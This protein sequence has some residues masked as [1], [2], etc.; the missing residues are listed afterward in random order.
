MKPTAALT[1]RLEQ[2]RAACLDALRG[3][4]LAAALGFLA[5]RGLPLER[6]M[7]LLRVTAESRVA[8][9]ELVE[10]RNAALSGSGR[11]MVAPLERVLLVQAAL[12]VMDRIPDLSVDESVKKL[13]CKEFVSYAWPPPGADERFAMTDSPFIGMSRIVFLLR[14]PAG[15]LHWERSGFPRRW[16]PSIPPGFLL[17]TLRFLALE[18]AAFKPYLVSHMGGTVRQ[19]PFLLERDGQ[20]SF[21]R[22]AA[23]I[24][25][26]PDVKAMMAGS[27]LISEETRR[28]SPH[29]DFL[30]RP[31]LEAGG[32]Y[33][34]AGPAHIDDGF[35]AG[36]ET[37]KKLYQAG[38]YKPTFGVVICTRRQAIAWKQANAHLD[39]LVEVK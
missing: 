28:V 23:A 5:G 39:P 34:E 36:D 4:E 6:R 27:W 7:E 24:E 33:T 18:A 38:Q 11:G 21:Y 37:R 2:A 22:M 30:A 19:Y 13:F 25:R 17:R 8:A 10:A 9:P 35:L 29:L 16:L 15:L 20:K 32:I 14:F 31:Y 1:E 3:D 26:Q 12:Q